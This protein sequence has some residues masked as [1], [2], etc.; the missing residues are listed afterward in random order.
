MTYQYIY[1]L[2][3]AQRMPKSA[4]LRMDIT[5]EE[6]DR[7]YRE[8]KNPRMKE[9]L[10]AISLLSEGRSVAEVARTLRRSVRTVERWVSYWNANGLEALAPQSSGGR[11]PKLSEEEWEEVLRE[12]EDKGYVEDVVVYVR[13]TRGVHYTY[14]GVWRVLRRRMR[15]KARYGKPRREEEGRPPDAGAILKKE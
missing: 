10:L 13:D 15:G 4:E 6:L 9:R 12:I 2:S 14:S 11:R 7:M 5:R 8:E 1:H 3:D